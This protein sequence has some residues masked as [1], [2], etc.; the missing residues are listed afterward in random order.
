MTWQAISTR[1]Y[2]GVS[3]RARW[4]LAAYRDGHTRL[5]EDATEDG[6]VG[7]TAP[8]SGFIALYLAMQLCQNV[9]GRRRLTASKSVPKAPMV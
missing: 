8:S 9:V 6:I 4:V 5:S 2:Y 7:G 3:T 1:P